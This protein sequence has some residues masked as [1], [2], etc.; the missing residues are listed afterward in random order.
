MQPKI[1]AI[2]PVYNAEKHLVQCIESVIKQ[3]YSSWELILVDDGSRDKS[4]AI[5]DRYAALD[6]RIKVIH[7]ENGGVSAARNSGME[8]AA[9]EYI[10][11]IDSDDYVEDS[12]FEAAIRMVC[13]SHAD[14]YISGI[15]EEFWEGNT[16]IRTTAYTNSTAGKSYSARE[17]LE[18]HGHDFPT[19][20]I[21]GPCCKLY[22][23]SLLVEHSILFSTKLW[24]GEDTLFNYMVIA[25]CDSF[26]FD[27][28]A[29]YHYRRESPESLFS[30]YCPVLY[31]VYSE[32]YK[33]KKMVLKKRQCA[34]AVCQEYERAY[35]YELLGCISHFFQ[36]FRNNSYHDRMQIIKR[37]SADACVKSIATAHFSGKNR[38]ILL[39]L[40]SR[41]HHAIYLLYDLRYIA[42]ERM[43]AGLKKR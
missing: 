24:R 35:V 21:S 23:R 11:F 42:K 5:C 30:R 27:Q 28:K 1:S 33:H 40:R 38:A 8:L 29:Y 18:A 39:M 32:L 13:A 43:T 16:I 31:D 19:I 26:V 10:T 17:L 3:T 20:C 14:V 6:D 22:K 15:K 36:F 7:K 37:V 34:Q 12:F 2:I 25:C 9:G 4:G 41:W